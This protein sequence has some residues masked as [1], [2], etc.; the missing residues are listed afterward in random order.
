M[1]EMREFIELLG[2]EEPEAEEGLW[3]VSVD[4]A[5]WEGD[6]GRE[7]ELK[8]SNFGCESGISLRE[9]CGDLS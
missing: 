8:L 1:V 4:L 9:H 6:Q 3:E 7:W 2:G 5:R